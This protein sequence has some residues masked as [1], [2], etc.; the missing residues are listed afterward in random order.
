MSMAKVKRITEAPWKVWSTCQSCHDW[1]NIS[2]LQGINPSRAVNSAEPRNPAAGWSITQD[3]QT[4]GSNQVSAGS[5]T[6][7]YEED[8]HRR[9]DWPKTLSFLPNERS[10]WTRSYGFGD[11]EYK[12]KLITGCWKSLRSES[13]D[14]C[15]SKQAQS[16]YS[17]NAG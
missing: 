17:A 12:G 7:S 14:R 3:L 13:T 8:R 6:A 15:R 11:L 1:A 9:Y 16:E 10:I 4:Q 5:A 2:D